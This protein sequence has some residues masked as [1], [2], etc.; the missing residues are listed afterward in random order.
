MNILYNIVRLNIDY[1]ARLVY[2]NIV[3]TNIK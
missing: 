1:L 3:N 2:N